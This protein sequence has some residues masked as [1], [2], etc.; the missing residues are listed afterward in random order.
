MDNRATWITRPD[1]YGLG[2]LGPSLGYTRIGREIY[3]A[4]RDTGAI[5]ALA[6]VLSQ[7]ND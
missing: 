7:I 3:I 4:D 5:L 1:T 6:L 2:R